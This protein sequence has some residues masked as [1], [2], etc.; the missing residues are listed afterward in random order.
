M[1]RLPLESTPKLTHK[2]NYAK[3]K[4]SEMYGVEELMKVMFTLSF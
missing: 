3:D 2:S 4:I 1:S